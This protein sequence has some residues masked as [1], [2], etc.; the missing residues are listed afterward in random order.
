MRAVLDVNVL[1]SA[2]LAPTGASAALLARWLRGEFELVVTEQLLAELSSSLA[3]P[4]LVSRIPREDAEAFIEL[5]RREAAVAERVDAP[6]PIRSR[7]PGDDYLLALAADADSVL[8]SWDR[9]L[10]ELRDA[11]VESPPHFLARLVEDE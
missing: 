5:L 7:D 8:V 2:L 10:L 3:Y 11:E 9:D 4:K 1:I 6:P